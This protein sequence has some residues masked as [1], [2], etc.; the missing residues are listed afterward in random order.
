MA[1]R[2]M[3][4][5]LPIIVV[6]F[7]LGLVAYGL[8]VRASANA[9]I[10]SAVGIRS[11]TDAERE[12][13]VWRNR[14]GSSFWENSVSFG[15]RT[16]DIHVE[17]GLLNRLGIAHPTMLGVTIAL[18]DGQL[19]YVTAV[20]FTGK[21]PASTAGVWIQE[22][23]G[24]GTSNDFR[25]H[26]DLPGKAKVEFSSVISESERVK[27]FRLNTACFVQLGGCRSAQ[28]IL[29]GIGQMQDK[30]KVCEPQSD[31][32]RVCPE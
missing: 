9:L 14:S 1:L 24:V 22:W 13:A 4:L 19:R 23:F 31:T 29:P 18:H 32:R 5:T 16:Y 26:K 10:N 11:T 28:E 2:R 30:S 12:I 6:A 3:L 27:A 25:V 7:V 21:T 20:M 15:D 8:R 17:N